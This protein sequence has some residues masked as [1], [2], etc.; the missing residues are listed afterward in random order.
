MTKPY[1]IL[2]GSA[3]GIG[4]STI[5]SEISKKLNIKYLLESDFIREVVREVIGS[6]FAP[7][8]H[9]SSFNAY[10]TIRNKEKFDTEYKLV[11]EGFED[12]SAYVI[13]AIE[14]V[15]KRSIKDN[16]SIVIEGVHLI[17]GL[18]NINQFTE[19]A[20][21]YFFILTAE[22]EEHKERFLERAMKIK[23]GGKHLDYFKENRIIND[24]LTI[25][26]KENNIPYIN[27]SNK[28]ETITKIMQ[29]I[30]ECC[31]EIILQH[32]IDQMEQEY[33]IV[34]KHNGRIQD[35]IYH[36]P[37]FKEPLKRDID[38][39]DETEYS[40]KF[41]NKIKQDKSQER[42]VLETLYEMSN[43]KH[44]HHICAPDKEK[45]EKIIQELK[46]NNLLYKE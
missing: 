8:L 41:I 2:I 36:I 26:A 12:H 16:D 21:V 14:K 15:I 38:N 25:K 20:N 3:S 22:L 10:T 17:P 43:N 1:V 29:R 11:A 33:E 30:N 45:L 5:A 34:R 35:I 44:S 32:T 9:K 42:K 46:E 7:A 27:N 40:K 6:E 4:K 31:K 23:R 37:D 39:Y 18:I 28:E 13:P 19:D 24:Y